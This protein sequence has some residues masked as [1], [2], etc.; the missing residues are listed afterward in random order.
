VPEAL[1]GS[2]GGVLGGD[3]GGRAGAKFASKLMKDDAH[4]ESVELDEP[5]EAALRT[6]RSRRP[7]A[8]AR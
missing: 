6:D 2:A 8:C 3:A 7:P 5:A 4:E 1:G